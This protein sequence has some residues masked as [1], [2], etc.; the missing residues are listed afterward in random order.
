[1]VTKQEIAAIIALVQIAPLQGGVQQ[2]AAVTELLG[3]FQS[4]ALLTIEEDGKAKKCV[5]GTAV[6]ARPVRA[7]ASAVGNIL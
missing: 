5:C 2:A 7:S 3:R 4:W 1:M 6:L